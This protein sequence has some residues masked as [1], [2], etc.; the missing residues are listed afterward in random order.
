MA[1]PDVRVRTGDGKGH[2]WFRQMVDVAMAT[3]GRG[4]HGVMATC[5]GSPRADWREKSRPVPRGGRYPAGEHCSQ[6]GL[7]DTYYVA[8][9]GKACAFLGDGMAKVERMEARVHGKE[10]ED[11]RFGVQE[12]VLVAKKR[13]PVPGAQ[14]TGVVTSVAIEMLQSGKVEAVVCVQ[15]QEDDRFAPKVVVATTP[16][17]IRKAKGV[18]PT[19]APNLDVLATVEAMQV[20][21]LLF[22]GVGC[23]VQ[24][25]RAVEP[26]LQL[27]KLYVMGTNCVDNGTRK[28]LEKFLQKAS[29]SPA[30]VQHYEFMQDYKVHF[31]HMDGRVEKVP[32]FC[33]PTNE[34]K[35][36]I[37]NSCYSCFD[38]TN[39]LADLVVGYMGVP[40]QGG[41]MSSHAQYITARNTKGLEMLE[42]IK[43]DLDVM[44]VVDTGDRK[45]FVL[46][47]VIADDDA[48]L[49]VSKRGPVP[50]FV[51]NVLAAVLEWIGPRGLEFARYSIDYHTI[52]NY[53]YV[54]RNFPKEFVDK[55]IPSYAKRIIEEYNREGLIEERLRHGESN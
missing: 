3:V 42:T 20:K 31:K 23:Q 19:L 10:R 38:Y 24:A 39:G 4:G 36:V 6:C 22:I 18:K 17:E 12:Q 34:L 1:T 54:R 53:L 47:T 52:R 16:E 5:S 48:T 27:E 50:L 8:H 28:G 30:T 11:D 25:L 35:D 41:S 37:A 26:Y 15:S 33:L 40:Y 51:G 49:G 32:Y 21:K 45:P 9:V 13:D 43:R 29:S 2:A 46:Q 55:A 7:C 14:W 44:P